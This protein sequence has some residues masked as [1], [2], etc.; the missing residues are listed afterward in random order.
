MTRTNMVTAVAVF[1]ALVV[2]V[3]FFINPFAN[4]SFVSSQKVAS[5]FGDTSDSQLV[6]QDEQVGTGAEAKA[7]DVVS[8]NYTGRL[9]D[10]VVFDSSVG[11]APA[12]GCDIGFCFVLGRGQVIPGWEQGLQ[13]MKVGGKRLLIIPPALAYG[14]Q[15]IG[16]IP[17]NATLIFEVELLKVAPVNSAQ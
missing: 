11:R 9:Q 5:V 8:V 13:G 15:G 1:A 17:P 3:L 10:G 16:P 4:S 14:Q 2:V 6:V 7:G 12:P